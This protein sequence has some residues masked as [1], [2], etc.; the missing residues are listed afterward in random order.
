MIT[1]AR[2]RATKLLSELGVKLS[3]PFATNWVESAILDAEARGVF[4]TNWVER[5]ILDA[6]ARGVR[7]ALKAMRHRRVH[8]KCTACE[9]IDRIRAAAKADGLPIEDET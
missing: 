7:L 2:E 8:K 9:S 4:A 5:A 1:T 6:E 3:E